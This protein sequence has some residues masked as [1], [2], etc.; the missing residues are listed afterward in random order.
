MTRSIVF[1]I[2]T[3]LVMIGIL[4]GLGGLVFRAGYFQGLATDGNWLEGPRQ[5]L[6]LPY[7][8][9]GGHFF[10]FG[11]IGCLIPLLLIFFVFGAMRMIF[12]RGAYPWRGM[13]HHGP[14][15]APWM[16]GHPG[17][18]ADWEKNAPPMFVE[19]HRRAHESQPPAGEEKP[20][21]SA[22]S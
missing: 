10:G 11:F 1:R 15:G 19:W 16:G 6:D 4:L 9:Y 13:H 7:R 17:E 21:S 8:G 3:A 18:K 5:Y 12:W 14:W 22:E 20:A 2:V